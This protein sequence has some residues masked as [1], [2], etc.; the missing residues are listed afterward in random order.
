MSPV[1]RTRT[2]PA[3]S[4]RR[5]ACASRSRP[6]RTRR[7]GSTRPTGTSPRRTLDLVVHLGDYIYEYGRRGPRPRCARHDGPE[8]DPRRATGTATRS[9]RPTRDFRRRTPPALVVTWD[10]HEVENNYA[11]AIRESGHPAERLPARRADRVPGLLRAHA[12]PPRLGAARAGPP[13][14]PAAS[15]TA[16]LAHFHVLDTR[17]YRTRPAVRRRAEARVAAVSIPPR[18]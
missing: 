4:A 12:A 10:D 9:T 17:Q 2:A 14:L 6:A 16:T 1:G 8:I 5:A 11:G 15:T 18:R 7:T 13:A 3:A